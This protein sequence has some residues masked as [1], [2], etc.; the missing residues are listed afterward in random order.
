L[1]AN[2]KC[3]LTAALTAPDSRNTGRF[4]SLWT[5]GTAGVAAGLAGTYGCLP[6]QTQP[7]PRLKS[8]AQNPSIFTNCGGGVA[9][10]GFLR[11]RLLLQENCLAYFGRETVVLLSHPVPI[12]STTG[13]DMVFCVLGCFCKKTVWPSMTG[14][15][16]SATL[17]M[18]LVGSEHRATQ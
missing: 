13:A 1:S 10:Y 9:R 12:S 8:M 11:P 2:D 3:R 17:P 6:L 15:R 7:R 5:A 18:P 16:A 14:P 4:C